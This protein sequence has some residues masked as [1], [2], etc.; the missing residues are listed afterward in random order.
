M[1][2]LEFTI[3]GG[4]IDMNCKD[5][6]VYEKER[7]VVDLGECA[8]YHT[9]D[10]PGYGL[11][12]GKWDL[13]GKEREYLGNVDLNGKRV[14][15][16]GTSSGFLCYYMERCGAEVIA[17]DIASDVEWDVVPFKQYDYLSKIE[18]FK[19]YNNR[20]KNAFWL[21]HR[22][23]NSNAKVCYSSIYDIPEDI[24]DVDIATLCS[25]LLHIRDPFRA[26][27]NVLSHV[28]ETVIITDLYKPSNDNY[29]KRLVRKITGKNIGAEMPCMEFLPDHDGI[30]NKDVWWG[31]NPEVIRRFI[32]VLGF[33]T[34][35]TS[36]HT[37]KLHGEDSRMFTVVGRRR[38]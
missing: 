31:L 21:A 10:I 4:I 22:A 11:V 20:M 16:M 35:R 24:G 8:F 7:G 37:Q 26:L 15:E 36:Y 28:K 14:L 12:E 25:I 19:D 17:H 2:G 3:K 27:Q 1:T 38:C 32:G 13:R 29:C 34:I 18:E 23:Y 33:D 6:S 9:M 30:K 5:R